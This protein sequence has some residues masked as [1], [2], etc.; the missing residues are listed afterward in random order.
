MGDI[1]HLNHEERME[2]YMYE[3]TSAI[4]R[5]TNVII[6]CNPDKFTRSAWLERVSASNKAIE[7]LNK[8][9]YQVSGDADYL[10]K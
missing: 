5:L 6:D 2:L 8:L 7:N 3:L 10:V 1:E 4:V 9:H